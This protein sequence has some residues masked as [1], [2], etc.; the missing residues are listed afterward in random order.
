MVSLGG[1]SNVCFSNK[2]S[3]SLLFMSGSALIPERRGERRFSEGNKLN[4]RPP[5]VYILTGKAEIKQ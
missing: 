1:Y 3:W 5:G 2:I 4:P